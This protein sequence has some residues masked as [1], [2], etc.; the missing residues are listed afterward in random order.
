MAAI[1][2]RE[3]IK[4]GLV[5]GTYFPETVKEVLAESEHFIYVHA[6]AYK[7]EYD[8]YVI[9]DDLS[10]PGTWFQSISST[11]KDAMDETW[12]RRMSLT[13]KDLEEIGKTLSLPVSIIEKSQ[14]IR[15]A[16]LKKPVNCNVTLDICQYYLCMVIESNSN[17]D[18]LDNYTEYFKGAISVFK[19]KIPYF[20][21]KR[22]GLR[23]F[24]QEQ[25]ETLE[26]AKRSFEDF[27]FPSKPYGL[28][29]SPLRLEYIDCMLTNENIKF[30][31]HS[32]LRKVKDEENHDRFESL[33][34]LDAYYDREDILAGDIN[35]LL[36]KANQKEFEVYKN[37][38]TEDYLSSICE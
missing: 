30:N 26:Q 14:V 25:K 2:A 20:R 4:P 5:Y 17:Y 23:K 34:D 31:I 37:C 15:Y 38:L 27:M 28:E 18:G 11:Q 35:A 22:L 10:Y 7:D 12:K 19:E 33:L 9:F 21:P 6:K 3:Q 32:M 24:R 1:T 16:Q 13:K 29:Y 36:E 8:L